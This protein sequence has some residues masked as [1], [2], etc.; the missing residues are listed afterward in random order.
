MNR[1]L[2]RVFVAQAI[3]MVALL[4]LAL[5]QYVHAQTETIDGL[6]RWGY[7]GAVARQ[8]AYDERRIVMIGGTRA[9]EP[10][11]PVKDTTIAR[12]RY[13]VEQWVTF[14]RGP[15]R[16]VNL[17]LVDLPRSE[18]AARLQHF[19]YL[20]PDVICVY[21]DLVP[22]SAPPVPG[23][24]MRA[25]GYVP[26]LWPLTAIDRQL[27][28]WLGSDPIDSDEPAAIADSVS[29]ARSIAP[30][31]VAVPEPHSPQEARQEAALLAALSPFAG[32]PAV[33]VVRLKDGPP[34]LVTG[35]SQAAIAIQIEAAVSTFFRAR[36]APA[37]K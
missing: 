9:F 21:P 2:T 30:T 18:Y 33:S 4:T 12:V 11:V 3:A 23:F 36:M 16:A 19:R 14:D 26:A 13:M 34:A 6:N 17:G 37:G 7:R 32:D 15:V 27:G 28:S 1:T 25:A 5:D 20:M 29:L 8:R 24:A 10:G 31:V 22:V 35:I